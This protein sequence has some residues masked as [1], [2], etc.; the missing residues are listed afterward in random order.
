MRLQRF[1]LILWAFYF[2]FIGGSTYYAIF[3]PVRVLHHGVVTLML[4]GWLL[5]RIRK[6][7]HQAAPGMPVTGL[8][9][10]IYA[11]IILW[12]ISATTAYDPRMAFEQVWFLVLSVLLFFIVADQIQRGRQRLVIEALFFMAAVV[13]LL[14]GI[15]LASWYFGLNITPGTSIGWIATGILPALTDFPQ[16]SM[17]MGISTLLAGYTAPLI[18]VSAGW[19]LTVRQRDYR[20]ALWLM[21]GLLAIVL[22]FTSSRG[23]ALSLMAATGTFI[24]T[25]LIQNPR[26]TARISPRIIAVSG[27]LVAIAALVAFVV[28]TLPNANRTSDA[29]RRDM[30]QSAV[31]LTLDHPLTGVGVGMFGRAFRDIRDPSIAQ[32]KLASAH[33]VYLNT[34]AET[35]LPGILLGS[36][37]MGLFG[38]VAWQNWKKAPSH[39]QKIRIQATFAALVGIA[40]HS[41]V[42]VFTIT[43]IVLLIVTLVAYTIVPQPISRL[44]P[45]TPGQRLPAVILLIV[46]VIYGAWWLRL[47]QAQAAYQR[48]FNLEDPAKALLAIDEAIALDPYLRLYPLQKAF[49]LGK[50]GQTEGAI[51]AYQHALELEPTWDVGWINLAS[52]L[53][54]QGKVEEALAALNNAAQISDY[55]VAA[56]NQARLAED[57]NRLNHEDIVAGYLQSIYSHV[58]LYLPLGDFW[59]ESSLRLQALRQFTLDAPIE[60]QYRIWSV[61]APEIAAT[62]IPQ[63][64]Q[65]A[66]DWWVM[67]ENALLVENDAQNAID[68]F[69]R[70]IALEPKTGD[71]YAS[72]ARALLTI[73][74][75][76]AEQN[77]D[78]AQVYGTR[79]ESVAAIRAMLA[80]TPEEAEKF[81]AQGTV[82]FV[83]QEFA[84]VLYA[85]PAVFDVP[86]AMR[87]P[88][89]TFSFS[90]IVP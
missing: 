32:D 68:Y 70:A 69:S 8:N 3:F 14:T 54:Q 80:T 50:T 6:R 38:R 34:A 66:M 40:V 15:E 57:N 10:P 63:N 64:P 83:P 89:N 74:P 56:L 36:I 37:L 67:G 59:H 43:P 44:T 62:L 19:A 75:A 60:W 5:G 1:M 13:I 76:D 17:A 4:T 87:Y 26:I 42:D 9:L 27:I 72:R 71:Y 84:A 21:T 28:L 65:T 33:N 52:L 82:R 81:A 29:G 23:G 58:H 20:V 55:N 35:G 16:V 24:L 2:T 25:Q 47:D 30:W 51:A 73:N 18:I 61:H 48:S 7:Q 77:L 85:R 78:L 45:V 79:F 11:A 53:E 86:P 46:I 31:Q 90:G 49:I 41:L 39:G 88:A 22:L 12:F